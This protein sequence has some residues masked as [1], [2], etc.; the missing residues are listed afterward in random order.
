MASGRLYAYT[1]AALLQMAAA[2]AADLIQAHYLA[3]LALRVLHAQ[4]RLQGRKDPSTEHLREALRLSRG[5]I[6]L[7]RGRTTA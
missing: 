7:D 6:G 5:L 1:G 4:G 2:E 3:H